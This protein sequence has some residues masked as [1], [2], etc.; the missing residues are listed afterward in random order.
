MDRGELKGI[1]RGEFR[2]GPVWSRG[3]EGAEPE[4]RIAEEEGPV[5]ADTRREQLE[6]GSAG[7]LSAEGGP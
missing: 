3:V 7:H 1:T 2:R 4:K 5:G 6:K